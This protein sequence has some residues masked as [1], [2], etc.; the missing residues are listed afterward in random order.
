MIRVQNTI[1]EAKKQNALSFAGRSPILPETGHLTVGK[2][3]FTLHMYS[4][5]R[6]LLMISFARVERISSVE[7]LKHLPHDLAKVSLRRLGSGPGS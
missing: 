1:S 7:M 6:L 2:V 4:R 5:A 3:V